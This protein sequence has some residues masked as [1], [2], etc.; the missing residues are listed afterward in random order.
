MNP[1]LYLIYYIFKISL[2][3]SFRIYYSS[4]KVLGREHLRVKG[5]FIV[6]SNHP[7][8]LTDPVFSG[9]Y[10]KQIMFF[11]ANSGLFKH[12]VSRWFFSTFYC[13][14]IERKE[15][16]EKFG[17]NGK[18]ENKDSFD[19]CDEFL[20]GGGVLYIA[21]EGTSWLDRVI[22]RIKTGTARIA[23]SAE[24]K[25]NFQLGLKIVPVGITYSDSSAFRS[26][27]LIQIGKPIAVKDYQEAYEEDSFKAVRNLT[28][29]MEDRIREKVVYALDDGE[30][31]LLEVMESMLETDDPKSQLESFHRSKKLE[32]GVRAFA[33][34]APEAYEQYYKEVYQYVEE[35]KANKLADFGWARQHESNKQGLGSWLGLLLGYPIFLYG[36]INNFL[37]FRLP[38]ELERW[39]QIYIG[40]RATIRIMSAGLI[41]IPL[42]Y[43]LQSKLV[44]VFFGT[45]VSWWYLLSLPI[46]GWLAWQY[47]VWQQKHLQVWRAKGW[48]KR[49]PEG[50]KSL[51][52]QRSSIKN[53]INLFLEY[54]DKEVTI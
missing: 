38:Y 7:N 23:F 31:A 51:T 32:K 20:S 12:P 54:Q 35:L 45:Q 46:S 48:S 29:D 15:D 43:W 1:I 50:A 49:N 42:F 22:Y 10:T 17:K 34:E 2:Y 4:V 40:Y 37:A 8:T 11:L 52:N 30:D 21:P 25:N 53:Q 47:Q 36:W 28:R 16:R 9:L 41:F 13:I 26:K 6:V 5:P 19:K 14:P 3:I 39:M 24:R 33:E 44:E 18:V 27:V